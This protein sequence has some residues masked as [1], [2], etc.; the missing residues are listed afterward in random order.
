[1]RYKNNL[2][3]W[4]IQFLRNDV[5]NNEKSAW[6]AVPQQY[7]TNNLAFAGKLQWHDPPPPAP[8]NNISIIPYVLGSVAKDYEAGTDYKP[9]GNIGFDAKIAV[10]SALNLDLTVN[11]DFSQVEVDQQVVNLQRF[12]LFFPEKRQF[13]LENSDLFAKAGFPSA[14]PFFSR[15]I[16]IAQD[17]SGNSVAVPIIY[18]ARLSGKLNKDWRIGLMNMQTSA[19]TGV[20]LPGSENTNDG[21]NLSGQNYTAAVLQR[22]IWARSNIGAIFINRQATGYNPEDTTH[23]TSAF[24]RVAGIDF[25]FATLDDKWQSNIFLHNSFDPDSKKNTMSHA[26]FVGYTSRHWTL[27]YYHTYVG[28]GFNAEVGFVPRKGVFGYGTFQSQYIIYPKTEKIVTIKPGLNVQIT[29][30]PDGSTA[31]TEIDLSAEVAFS[32]TSQISAALR[33]TYTYLFSEFDPTRSGGNGE[34]LP[35]NSEYS[36]YTSEISYTSDARK[37]FS[38]TVI[39]QY[40]NFYNGTKFSLVSNVGYRCRPYGS[41]FVSA[42]YNDVQ[43]PEPYNSDS[44]WLI[45]PRVDITFTNSLFLTTFVQYN[46]QADN[47]NINARFQWRFAPVSDLFIVYT[48]NYFPTDFKVKNRSIVVKLSYWLNL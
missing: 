2:T 42:I 6:T 20:V 18:G 27:R 14:R 33:Q 38:Y 13:F 21:Y 4:N 44:F 40:G 35:A 43:L 5:K 31:D 7:R 8:K 1:M 47:V 29:L 48:D 32:N 46:E 17:T 25:N 9:D 45:G 37:A 16:G 23:S 3:N 15:R 41:F 26:A 28:Q 12:E 10:S 19:Q 36:W 39:G 34:P 30:V 11:P 22:K 24:N